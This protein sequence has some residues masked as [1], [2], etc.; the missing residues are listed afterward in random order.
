MNTAA[1]LFN[2]VFTSKA[3]YLVWR[4][5]WRFCYRTLSTEIRELKD[6]IRELQK[7]RQ[8][9]G[10]L[11]SSLVDKR[12]T[13]T[14]LLEMRKRSKLAAAQAYSASQKLEQVSS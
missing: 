11:Q 5:G 2:P 3:E 12:K 1:Y 8:Y 13:A 7:K 6:E 4:D 10:L 9:A 14:R